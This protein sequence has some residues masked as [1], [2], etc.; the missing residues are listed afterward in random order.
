MPRQADDIVRVACGGLGGGDVREELLRVRL[1]VVHHAQRRGVV[2]NLAARRVEEV[3][4]RVVR[5]VAVRKLQLRR[6]HAR[7]ERVRLAQVAVGREDGRRARQEREARARVEAG[8]LRNIGVGFRVQRNRRR[9]LRRAPG[10]P[11]D[12]HLHHLVGHREVLVILHRR[13]RLLLHLAGHLLVPLVRLVVPP[14]ERAPV[15]RADGDEELV[16]V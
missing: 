9:E 8:P 5:A 2:H 14:L 13:Q 15:A 12:H 11:D 3:I 10:A 6:L 1:P 4:A 16:V 7:R